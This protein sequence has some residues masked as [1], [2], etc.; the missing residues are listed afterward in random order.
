MEC[1]S[2]NCDHEQSK[3]EAKENNQPL[4]QGACIKGQCLRIKDRNNHS[5]T[6]AVAAWKLSHQ[7]QQLFA[8]KLT[9]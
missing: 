4:K 7:S 1:E 6:Q 5:Y 2:H 3:L 8:P 9:A